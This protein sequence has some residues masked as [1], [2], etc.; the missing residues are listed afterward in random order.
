MAAVNPIPPH[1]LDAE[2]SALGSMMLDKGALDR[3]LG[4]LKESDFYRIANQYVFTALAKLSAQNTPPDLI[5]TQDILRDMKRLE[6]I[7]GT[8]YLM[9]LVNSVPTAANFDH[10]AKIVLNDSL[11]RQQ[12]A[13][14]LQVQSRIATGEITDPA[15]I[16]AYLGG[17]LDKLNLQRGCGMVKVRDLIFSHTE[18]IESRRGKKGIAGYT[19]G[20]SA[21]DN[22]TDGYGQAMYVLLRGERGSGKTHLAIQSAI[23][24]LRSGKAVA[25]FSMDTPEHLMMN[26]FI[27]HLS[28]VNSFRINNPHD[29]DW[30]A[31]VKAQAQLWEWP[32]YFWNEAGITMR[33]VRAMCKA[34]IAAG[35]ELG[36]VVIDYAELL[37][38]EESKSNHEQEL[39]EVARGIQNLRKELNT[40][41]MLLSQVNAEGKERWSKSLGNLA[42]V[43]MTWS[44]DKEENNGRGWGKLIAEKNRL[45]SNFTISCIYDA[46]TS[47]IR[48]SCLDESDPSYPAS[49]PWWYDPETDEGLP[50]PEPT[51]NYEYSGSYRRKSREEED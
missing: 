19:T 15:E 39:Q 44:K 20:F 5:S 26:R 35:E 36:L 43:V 31:I 29:D 37:G 13:I 41:I 18:R 30:D 49:W 1:N 4:I 16:N 28:G 42:D 3:G 2:M 34:I 38:Y 6:D 24:C 51:Q 45:N 23:H 50:K 46:G 33:Q 8:E 32:L 25:F 22:R 17:H 40:T 12:Q 10:Y 9:S 14:V 27:A 47:R 21:M 11:L 7:G 48:E